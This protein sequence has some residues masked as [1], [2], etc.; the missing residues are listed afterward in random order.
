VTGD[1][2]IQDV[3]LPVVLDTPYLG[4][5]KDRFGG[6]TV[7]VFRA[8]TSIARQDF[9]VTWTAALEGGGVYLGSVWR[10]RW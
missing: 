3:T 5:S 2:T 10:S 8:E 4:R 9:G 1:L 7:A 6:V